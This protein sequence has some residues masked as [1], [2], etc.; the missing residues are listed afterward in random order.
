LS[1]VWDELDPAWLDEAVAT[2][3][4]RG[5]DP[6]FVLDAGEEALFRAR[7]GQ[8]PSNVLAALDWPPLA[9]VGSQVRVYAPGDRERYLKGAAKPTE[10]AP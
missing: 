7:F 2:L 4:K 3:R 6:Y 8:D 1:V 9:E 5:L 10:Y